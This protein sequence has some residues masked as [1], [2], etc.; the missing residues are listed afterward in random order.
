MRAVRPSARDV[1]RRLVLAERGERALAVLEALAA[2]LAGDAEALEPGDLEL[3]EAAGGVVLREPGDQL[4]DAVA[5]LQGE[6][7]G[8]GAH[9]LA[10][11]VDRH[12]VLRAQALGLLGLGHG[13]QSPPVLTGWI[14]RRV[15]MRDWTSAE[16]AA[17]SPISQP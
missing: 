8:G 3:A 11:V 16:M 13:V 1:R 7:R 10:D 4:A 15:S 17:S 6:V 9:Q 2:D 14:S 5:Q 12:L